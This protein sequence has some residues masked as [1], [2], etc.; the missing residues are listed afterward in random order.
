[1]NT[2]IENLK[3][4]IKKLQE[5]RNWQQF[6]SPKNLSI[7]L[8]L[9]ASEVME[10]FVWKNIEESYSLK[11]SE[12]QHL[13]EEL[14]DVLIVLLNLAQKFNVDLIDCATEKI[15]EIARKYPVEKAKGN[16]AK[17]TEHQ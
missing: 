12:K 16:N 4:E 1:M 15:K 3:K 9:E 10:I 11:D 2:N 17:Y 13:K 7:A 5:E 6:H 8:V 14:G